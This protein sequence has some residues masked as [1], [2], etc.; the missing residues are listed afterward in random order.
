MLA[1]AVALLRRGLAL[2]PGLPDNDWRRE[3]E[4]ELQVA[5]GQALIASRGWGLPEVSEVHCRVRELASTLNRPRAL[6]IA[7]WG[8]FMDRWTQADLEGARQLAAELR[9]LGDTARDI[10]MQV[11]GCNSAGLTCFCLGE[12][13]AGRAHLEKA[14]AL[15]DP[16][17]R[18]YYAELLPH[19]ARVHL[20][21]HSA[22]LLAC[23]GHLDQAW[24]QC[25][26]ALEEARR[27]FHPPT[28]TFALA[29]AWV[30]GSF[31][32][33]EAGSLFQ[34]ANET[35]ELAAENGLGAYRMVA[36]ILRGWSLAALGRTDE[37]IPLLSAGLAGWHELGNVVLRPWVRTL[38][39]D[40]C[41]MAG[42]CQT[43]LEHLAEARHLADKREERWFLAETLRIAGEALLAMGDRAN[44]EAGYLEAIAI[45]R[46][47]GA[48]LW[49]LRAA[50]S[51]A[52]LW[53]DQGKSSEAR[54]L[55]APVYDW[56]TEGFGTPVLQEAQAL[57]EELAA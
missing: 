34:Y 24:F 48:K 42:Q 39:G 32:R 35:L 51:L 41:R 29:T 4:F 56:F 2:L 21:R 9:E 53:R 55:L 30:T 36:L 7:L 57:R 37:G 12:F 15:Y 45:A 5:L 11:L 1:E 20:R 19:D 38:L 25:E 43:A 40:A 44:A 33:L 14:F 49:E 22:W 46:R 26:A 17:D 10:P 47:Q 23:L 54:D 16:A 8:Q 3:R 6:L 31:V 27:L 28:L 52:R 18:P 50:T 13:I